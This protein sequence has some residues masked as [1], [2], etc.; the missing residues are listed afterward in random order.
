MLH[1]QEQEQERGADKPQN[2]VFVWVPPP[3]V[4][5]SAVGDAC[6]PKCEDGF[7]PWF[8]RTVLKLP[9]DYSCAL[10]SDERWSKEEVKAHSTEGVQSRPLSEGVQSRS[11]SEGNK[12][13]RRPMSLHKELAPA[14]RSK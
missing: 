4:T 6:F 5:A 7:D 14:K 1:R 10:T 11:P 8:R 2:F 3:L 9:S 13:R 12:K